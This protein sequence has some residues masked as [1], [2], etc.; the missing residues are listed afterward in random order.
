MREQNLKILTAF[1]LKQMEVQYSMD[2]LHNGPTPTNEF[3]HLTSVVFAEFHP[4]KEKEEFF[5]LI[6]R[7]LVEKPELK[8]QKVALDYLK[9]QK[10][11]KI[12]RFETATEFFYPPY[13]ALHLD[14]KGRFFIKLQGITQVLGEEQIVTVAKLTNLLDSKEIVDFGVRR[15]RYPNWNGYN[16]H[17]PRPQWYKD[18]EAKIAKEKEENKV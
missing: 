10:V 6:R 18:A 12:N 11:V 2:R 9:T 13:Y 7:T 5:H 8:D 15:L 16:F 14:Y 17:N 4:E 3:A 1:G